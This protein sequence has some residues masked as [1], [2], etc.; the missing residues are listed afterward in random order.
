MN[1]QQ[2][3]LAYDLYQSNPG[4][5]SEEEV[6]QL[7][8]NSDN[9]GVPFR[10]SM[11]QS[12]FNLVSTVGQ[13][14]SGFTSGFSTLSVGDPPENTAEAIARNVGH[15]AGFVGW[16]PGPWTIGSIGAKSVGMLAKAGKSAGLVK[17]TA[18]VS[19]VAGALTSF[20]SVPMLAADLTLEG[21]GRVSKGIV[22]GRTI[23]FLE[24]GAVGA[25]MLRHAGHLG[26]ASAASTWQEGAEHMMDAFIGGA[27]MGGIFGGIGNV[28]NLQN[29]LKSSDPN[30]IRR[31]NST[32]RAL[33]GSIVTGLPSTVQDEPLELQVYQYLLGAFFGAKTMPAKEEAALRF[34]MPY[35]QSGQTSKLMSPED[36]DGFSKMRPEVQKEIEHQADLLAGSWVNK[37]KL[38]RAGAI[39]AMALRDAGLDVDMN[40]VRRRIVGQ[41]FR[42]ASFNAEKGEISLDRDMI[43]ADYEAN[44]PYLRGELGPSSEQKKIMLNNMDIR[45]KDLRKFFEERGGETAYENFIMLHEEGHQ[46]LGHASKYPKTEKGLDLFADKALKIEQEATEYALKQMNHPDYVDKEFKI[47]VEPSK[48]KEPILE[49]PTSEKSETIQTS[50]VIN[51][52]DTTLHLARPLDMI[53]EQIV[54]GTDPNIPNRGLVKE[55]VSEIAKSNLSTGGKEGWGSFLADISS[56]F[57]VAIDRNTRM[58]QGLRSYW[59]RTAENTRLNEGHFVQSNEPLSLERSG[60]LDGSGKNVLKMTPDSFLDKVF[61][62]QWKWIVERFENKTE[63]VDPDR[64]RSVVQNIFDMN[65]PSGEIAE[66]FAAAA[67]KGRYFFSGVKDQDKQIYAELVQGR[68]GDNFVTIA[69]QYMSRINKANPKVKAHSDYKKHR[70]VFSSFMEKV[71]MPAE[72]AEALYAHMVVSNIHARLTMEKIKDIG[73][74]AKN[75]DKFLSDPVSLSKRM[76]IL[77][78]G[79]PS[80]DINMYQDHIP[81]LSVSVDGRPA[82]NIIIQN[83]APST[84]GNYVAGKKNIMMKRYR[85]SKSGKVT[86]AVENFLAEHHLDGVFTVRADFFDRMIEDGGLP[87]KGNMLKGFMHSSEIDRGMILGKYAYFRA[88]KAES[89]HMAGMSDPV[90]GILYNTAVKQLGLREKYDWKLHRRGKDKY[91]MRY[92][93]ESTGKYVKTPETYK[94]PLEDVTLNL[95]VYDNPTFG[96]AMKEVM[97]V[98]QMLT[99]LFAEQIDPKI[100]DRIYTDTL[101]ASVRGEPVN[102][103]RAQKFLEL[104]AAGKNVTSEEIAKLEKLAESI[105]VDKIDHNIIM[106][107]VT[108]GKEG[109]TTVSDSPLYRKLWD[110]MLKLGKRG[111]L[112]QDSETI[113]E[114]DVA[115]RVAEQKMLDEFYSSADRILQVGGRS[116][117]MIEFKPTKKLTDTVLR[118]YLVN[119]AIRPIMPSSGKA[120]LN[121]FDP[122]LMRRLDLKPGEFYFN[123]ALKKFKITYEG[124]SMSLE[125]AWKHYQGVRKD[126]EKRD[127]A[128]LA[129]L[130]EQLT[131]GII[132]VP[133]DSISGMRSLKFKGFTGRQGA[134]MIIHNKDM[135]ASGGAD[136]D[137]D[138]AFFYHGLDRG[139]MKAIRNNRNEWVD[140]KGIL[141]DVKTNLE[142]F[143]IKELREEQKGVPGMFDPLTLWEVSMGSRAGNKLLGV[144]AN[145]RRRIHSLFSF[146]NS[147][148]GGEWVEELSP[149]T[150]ASIN[151]RR[152]KGKKEPIKADKLYVKWQASK[153]NGEEFRYYARDALNFAADAGDYAGMLSRHQLIDLLISKA[154]RGAIVYDSKG[155][156][157]GDILSNKAMAGVYDTIYGRLTRMDNLIASRNWN[158][159]RAWSMNDISDRLSTE[160]RYLT[161][162]DVEIPGVWGKVVSE[163]LVNILKVSDEYQRGRHFFNNKE[164]Q[165]FGR[166]FNKILDQNPDVL[167]MLFREKIITQEKFWDDKTFKTLMSTPE[168]RAKLRDFVS[169]DSADRASILVVSGAYRKAFSEHG[170]DIESFHALAGDILNQAQ[171]HKMSYY[172]NINVKRAVALHERV[173]MPAYVT[174]SELR[175]NMRSYREGLPKAQQELYDAFLLSSLRRHPFSVADMHKKVSLHEKNI[176]ALISK[177]DLLEGGTKDYQK[178][179]D[180]ITNN[181][182]REQDKISSIKGD[183]HNSGLDA[184]SFGTDVLPRTS[185]KKWLDTYKGLHEL[186]G[187]K[188]S[189]TE[190]QRIILRSDPVESPALDR[191]VPR[192]SDTNQANK[193]AEYADHFWR[194]HIK[195][196]ENVD[197][198]KMSKEERQLYSD[199]QDIVQMYPQLR[200][201]FQE[202]FEGTLMNF[203]VF[204]TS[205]RIATKQDLRVFINSF[206]GFTPKNALRSFI[207]TG[208]MPDGAPVKWWHFMMWPESI[209]RRN[210]GYDMSPFWMEGPVVTPSGPVFK[211]V[212]VPMSHFGRMHQF[213]TTADKWKQVEI[214]RIVH[215]TSPEGEPRKYE[216]GLQDLASVREPLDTIKDIDQSRFMDNII[217]YRERNRGKDEF[218]NDQNRLYEKE[219]EKAEKIWNKEFAGKEYTITLEGEQ[220]KIRA[221]ELRD[222]MNDRVSDWFESFYKVHVSNRE[223]SEKEFVW[224]NTKYGKEI[225]V[226]KTL[227][228]LAREQDVG[229]KPYIIPLEQQ[230]ELSFDI[231][232]NEMRVDMLNIKNNEIIDIA[233]RLTK[234]GIK[235]TDGKVLNWRKD[236]VDVREMPTELRIKFKEMWKGGDETR[237]TGKGDIIVSAEDGSV[238]QN[239]GFR[240]IGKVAFS[241][242]FPHGGWGKKVANR[243]LKERLERL[244]KEGA[245]E[246][247]LAEA[248]YR[249]KIIM[250]E[251]KL[252]DL[253][254]GEAHAEAIMSDEIS[255]RDFSLLGLHSRP[256]HVLRRGSREDGPLPG[257]QRNWDALERYASQIIT[258]RYNSLASAISY[259][260]VKR[261]ENTKAMGEHTRQWARFMKLYNRDNL[262]YGST[263]PRAFLTDA[264][265]LP[266][267]MTPYYWFSDEAFEKEVVGRIAKKYFDGDK[268]LAKEK[269]RLLH[270]QLAHLSNLEAKWEMLTLLAHSKSL[271]NNM[272]GGSTN[273]IINAGFEPWKNSLSIKYLANYV[274]PKF[275]TRQDWS[276][277]TESV[278]A[279][280]SW[281][282]S[283][284]R[285]TGAWKDPKLRK[286]I[287]ESLQQIRKEPESDDLTVFEIFQR[288]GVTK[289]VF[290]KA[291][292]F[293]RVSERKLRKQAFLAHYINS[294]D[295]LE[296]NGFVMDFEHPW[297]IKMANQG[298]YG[299]QFL[300]NNANRPAFARTNLGR[301]FARFQLWSWNSIRFRKELI[302]RA[303][304]VGYDPGT[305]EYKRLQN[306]VT[307]DLFMY[308]LATIFP[309]SM[310][311]ATLPQPYQYFEDLAGW[312]FGSDKEKERAFFGMGPAQMFAPPVARYALA[313]IKS[314]LSK[315]WD[316]FASY[317]VWTWFPFGRMARDMFKPE[318]G[319][320]YNPVMATE[321]LVGV[322]LHQFQ[323]GATKYFRREKPITATDTPYPMSTET[324]Y[325]SIY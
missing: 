168:G 260:L 57:S 149:E 268:G 272:Y 40:A 174:N 123:D 115:Q 81:D 219:W 38:S 105:D 212:A 124:K 16:L 317:H 192:T 32:V 262:G 134:G 264:D 27:A 23:K 290:N 46:A 36:L 214:N 291:A 12:D 257:W 59:V 278:G 316:R 132:R 255:E 325:P 86:K 90:H 199:L 103:Q 302:R 274:N 61:G 301:I 194:N 152:I 120:F 84:V 319:L 112:D 161:D 182:N 201:N 311:E 313:P 246:T 52:H 65:M 147:K 18:D 188:L 256:G 14:V 143:N 44:H 232:L 187:K 64:D 128:K 323:R 110:H 321:R 223:F 146:V 270:R 139:F 26:V 49:P 172:N 37:N 17:Q 87:V 282:V 155:K 226:S 245:D 68:P 184:F 11:P 144:A 101:L 208:K 127:P 244:A 250:A 307:A 318:H 195:D 233:S 30:T 294:R 228:K 288:N 82:M 204:G 289:E 186:T 177:R 63:V 47:E 28:V 218:E 237:I 258:A 207:K 31:A 75:P 179:Y 238:S 185:V 209:G 234:E 80:L 156:V 126:L 162:R 252:N 125:S 121:P 222:V 320:I 211:Q 10:R 35:R 248:E 76:Q 315:D 77:N 279:V 312:F 70:N 265:K 48:A 165:K 67:S 173:N 217:A 106:A 322:P 43:R 259:R 159:G 273:T 54:A 280:E 6:D 117:S 15:L 50:D 74:I 277:W 93:N 136:L 166:Q 216:E 99:N 92:Y 253:G 197:A 20:R 108:G 113:V 153:D 324:K 34:M 285:L 100:I 300:Y 205:P 190:M 53:V 71:G 303:K 160:V 230:L 249:H 193:L 130:E 83:S 251:E 169:Q 33:A 114:F 229:A 29:A 7:E 198:S 221:E 178:D 241:E 24:E 141:R 2:F 21:V 157:Y 148:K 111:L 305:P 5:F 308:S 254:L 85:K 309:A 119:K 191:A 306:M 295:A 314:M 183:Y 243:V 109:K 22:A 122:W 138:S 284:A 240:G 220:Q 175:G 275:K 104:E 206:K 89:A 133:S 78:S 107:I 271:A 227:R 196:A 8:K 79:E 215:R 266:V 239:P 88:G 189:D 203:G 213:W 39:T 286:S 140:K 145:A 293:M 242:F 269:S 9:F 263:F 96:G 304:I 94:I 163:E 150:L 131:F 73:V 69:E 276:D 3:R 154:F 297:L 151:A 225:D 129:D 210:L 41:D 4:L 60:D 236:I 58:Y 235:S 261:F 158:E 91:E 56:E 287:R 25:Q 72:Q 292:W 102:N 42:L 281:I 298:V 95:Q 202:M 167:S 1:P 224:N 142:D 181:M 66:V 51:E 267:K 13:L 200:E 170:G 283:E 45:L 231:I 118:N 135:I 247:K 171:A 296:A 180:T 116:P 97:A 19:K 176:Q 137:S 310:F 62:R 164:Y 299:T 55:R 98:R